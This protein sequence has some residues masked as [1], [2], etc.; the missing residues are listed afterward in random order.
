MRGSKE[1]RIT[2]NEIPGWY[3][4]KGEVGYGS[5][6]NKNWE[7]TTKVIELDSFAF[8]AHYY[9]QYILP[10]AAKYMILF[11]YAARQNVTLETSKFIVSINGVQQEITP[12]NY[13]VNTYYERFIGIKGLNTFELFGVGPADHYGVT[14]DNVRLILF[15]YVPYDNF[16]DFNMGEEK[17]WKITSD[18]PGWQVID[19]EVGYS[20]LYNP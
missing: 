10:V 15:N 9:A 2:G 13:N 20:T 1:Y 19:G 4:D 16:E 17:E 11:D 7:A 3:T 14:V 6:Y 18:I 12:E 8:N 5:T